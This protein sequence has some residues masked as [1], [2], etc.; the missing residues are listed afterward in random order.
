LLTLILIIV[1]S[2]CYYPKSINV[3]YASKN[4]K[5]QTKFRKNVAAK[6]EIISKRSVEQKDG[7]P[8]GPPPTAFP[9]VK[10]IYEPLSH[11]GNRESYQVE[12]R[13]YSILRTASGYKARGIASWYGT[14]F[15]SQRTSSGEEY[16][17]YAM[18]AAHKTLPLPT[19]VRV[20]NLHN[21]HEAIVKVNDRGPFRHDRVIDLSYAAATKLGLLPKGTAPVEIEAL[22]IP[23]KSLLAHYYVQVGAFSSKDLANLLQKKLAKFTPSP[24]FVEQYKQ[25]FIVKVGP[26]ADKKMTELFKMQ[27]AAH[28]VSGSFTMLQ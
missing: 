27:L 18:T 7:A 4:Q 8:S 22:T 23:G 2:S 20:K 9:Y 14:K 26:F 12:G 10:P 19:Y 11:Y 21:G 28:G 6:K 13:N 25:R 16:N 24:V 3:G 15:H 5:Q 1:A 17:M